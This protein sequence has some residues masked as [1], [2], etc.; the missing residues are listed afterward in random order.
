MGDGELNAI[1]GKPGSNV[2]KHEYFPDMG[3]ELKDVILS[4]PDYILGIQPLSLSHYR[5]KV[6][7]LAGDL[8]IDWVNSDVL[9]DANITEHLKRFFEVLKDQPVIMI[10]PQRLQKLPFSYSRFIEIPLINCWT[11]RDRVV[12]ELLTLLPKVDYAVL[13]FCASM[14]TNVM[15]HDLYK[16]YGNKVTMI[17][18]GSCLEPHCGFETRS[19]HKK[20]EL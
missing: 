7:E 5:D 20:M 11:E 18:L 10:A 12:N 6:V 1:F 2:D 3:K 19:Y 9:H 8:N 13:L 15:I 4:E 17:D 14:S 16:Y